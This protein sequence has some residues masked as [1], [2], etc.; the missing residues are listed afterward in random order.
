MAEP[1]EE[2]KPGQ[3]EQLEDLAPR[4]YGWACLRLRGQ[5]R[6]NAEDLVQEVLC[7][8]LSALPRFRGGDLGG[9]TFQIARNV[10]LESLR[11]RRRQGRVQLPEGHSSRFRALDAVPASVTTLTRRVA[12][13]E[14]VQVLLRLVEDLDP[15]DRRLV[16]LCGLEGQTSVAAAAVLGLGPEA[17]AKRWYRLR[18]RLGARFG[19]TA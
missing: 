6:A 8:A 11:T 19:G 3:L 9:W 15:V 16:E 10:L 14:E 5:P 12:R 2:P 4:L 13:N 18:Q 7:R 17:S 1:R